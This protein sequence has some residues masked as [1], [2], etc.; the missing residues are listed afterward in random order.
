MSYQTEENSF[1][2]VSGYK[3]PSV[4]VRS[5]IKEDKEIEERVI[6][7]RIF[8]PI[9]LGTSYRYQHQKIEIIF[10]GNI[11]LSINNYDLFIYPNACG[12]QPPPR[13]WDCVRDWEWDWIGIG[14]GIGKDKTLANFALQVALKKPRKI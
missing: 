6:N 11:F 4:K 5:L 3:C 13:F 9:I 10:R 8:E 2:R 12:H 7:S 1:I 14:I